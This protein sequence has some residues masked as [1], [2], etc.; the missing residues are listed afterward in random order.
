MSKVFVPASIK[1]K[2]IRDTF[3]SIIK[4]IGDG[5][6]PTV[7]QYDPTASTIGSPGQLIYSEATN[8]IWMFINSAWVKIL[9][10]NGLNNAT[11]FLYNKSTASSLSKTF[12]GDFTYTFATGTL[13][14][15]TL[16]GWSTTIPSLSAGEN[17]F[18]SLAT[19]T[20]NTTTDTIPAS[21]FSTPEIFSIAGLDGA[22]TALITL[23]KVTNSNSTP[24]N[25]TGT[26]TY[27]FDT[28]SLTGGTLNGWSTSAPNVGYGQYSWTISATAFAIGNT[29]TI[30]ATEFTSPTLTGVPAADGV[31]GNTGDTGDTIITG[32]VYYGNL[33][34]SS[35]SAPNATSW[36]TNTSTFIGLTSNWSQNQPPVNITD[37]SL[38]EWSSFFTV[39]IDGSNGSQNISFT[40]P[41]GAIQ[42]TDDIESDNY[43]S[44]SS[45]W[46]IRRDDGY[47]EFGAAAIRGQLTASQIAANAITADK[48]NVSSLDAI[49]ANLGSITVGSANIGNLAVQN[50]NLAGNAVDTNNILNNA[51][52]SAK[53]Q[54]LA[55]TNAKIGNLS[56]DKIT[57][58]TI[59]AA[60]F[61]GAGIAHVGTTAVNISAELGTTNLSASISGLQAGTQLIGIAGVSGYSTATNGSRSFTTTA[62]LSGAGSS[63]SVSTI[64]GVENNSGVAI[65]GWLGAVV[66]GVTTTTGTATLSVTIS[67]ISAS[68]AAGNTAF[69]GSIV[70]LGVQG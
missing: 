42:V 14:G 52:T 21:E 6:K 40:T 27:T 12:S 55:V 58:G 60:R 37:T 59:D 36:N 9:G 19:A 57:A 32:K 35:P 4:N 28:Q 18:V 64:N 8:S 50:V 20:S 43:S 41:S 15:G 30:A 48:I 34:S 22:N 63:G 51:I 31:D 46:S 3:L 69:K 5:S 61:I 66:S 47:A 1:D 70:I 62:S 29:D 2:A 49:S 45:G 24:S 11:I 56:A 53:I 39:T 26:F 68:G 33:Q 13:T 65:G 25:P 7:S 67:R 54:D 44:G 16:N 10:T 38:R 17:L 23:Y